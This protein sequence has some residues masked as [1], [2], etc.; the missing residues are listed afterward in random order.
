VHISKTDS[1]MK[2]AL[3]RYGCGYDPGIYA[4]IEKLQK[5]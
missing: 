5:F 4:G 2:Y 3:R 1:L